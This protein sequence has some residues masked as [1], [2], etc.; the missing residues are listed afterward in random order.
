MP[1][2][3]FRLVK[4][5][6]LIEKEMSF[7]ELQASKNECGTFLLDEGLALRDYHSE[8][9]GKCLSGEMYKDYS[10]SLAVHPTQIAEV[11]EVYRRAGLG[12]IEHNE[13]GEPFRYDRAT[14]KKMAEARGFGNNDGGYGDAQYKFTYKEPS[15]QD[16][17]NEVF[18][19][20]DE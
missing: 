1:V 12:T 6:S 8:Q 15:D 11:Q 5:D 9:A 17:I 4:D 19:G 14:F 18:G 7:E 16:I 2:Y 20:D 3:C 10:T 13:H